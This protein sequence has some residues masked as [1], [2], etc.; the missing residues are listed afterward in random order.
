[1]AP[2]GVRRT[3]TALVLL[4]ACQA[5]ESET[6]AKAKQAAA[7]RLADPSSARF[8]DMAE[9]PVKGMATG[10]VNG[11]NAT[12]AYGGDR[13]FIYEHGTVWMSDDIDT[14]EFF[15]VLDRCHGD[16]PGTLQNSINAAPYSADSD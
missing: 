8:T 6:L 1:M 15:K 7:K 13:A 3:L 12:G 5:Q 4:T 16:K 10:S 11:K 14:S 2:P 9:C